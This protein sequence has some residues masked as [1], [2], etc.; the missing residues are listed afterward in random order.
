MRRTLD[1]ISIWKTGAKWMSLGKNIGE[2]RLELPE[3]KL[4]EERNGVQESVLV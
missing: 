3:T 1:R 4:Q 2:D